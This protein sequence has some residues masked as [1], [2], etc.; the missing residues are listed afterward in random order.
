MK[1]N[2]KHVRYEDALTDNE[3]LL[4]AQMIDK[5]KNGDINY[6]ELEN[7]FLSNGV[8]IKPTLV[9]FSKTIMSIDKANIIKERISRQDYL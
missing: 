5:F 2:E 6:K 7:M 8:T 1:N 3:I 4:F 9:D